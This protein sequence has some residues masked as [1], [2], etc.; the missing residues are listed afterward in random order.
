MR[1]ELVDKMIN[2]ALAE[3]DSLKIAITISL[4]DMGG[5]LIALR[6]TENCGFFGIEVSKKKAVT[7]SQLKMPTHILADIGQK[8][9]ELQKAFDKDSNILT[10]A[11]GFP[12]FIDSVLVGGLGI[13]GGDFNQDKMI[14]EKALQAIL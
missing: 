13:S 1:R 10:I 7:A 12:I 4:V 6:R 14:G 11:G 9:P 8:V 2:A 5:H 3:A